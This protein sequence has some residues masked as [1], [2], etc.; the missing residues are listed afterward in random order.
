M[1]TP[2]VA[3]LEKI[4]RP[5]GE[6]SRRQCLIGF[7]CMF[8]REAAFCDLILTSAFCLLTRHISDEGPERTDEDGVDDDDGQIRFAQEHVESSV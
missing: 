3:S 4:S 5:T 6:I 2:N 8:F 7:S 1:P